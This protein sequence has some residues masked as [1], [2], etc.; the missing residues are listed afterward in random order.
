MTELKPCPFCGGEAY[1]TE[2]A[3]FASAGW[4]V[5]CVN[6]DCGCDFALYADEAEAIGAWNTRA[7]RTCTNVD[8]NKEVWFICSECGSTKKLA[9]MGNYCMNCGAK[10]VME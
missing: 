4:S 10:V 8:D 7:E 5:E 2:R 1:T 9:H 6:P 3:G